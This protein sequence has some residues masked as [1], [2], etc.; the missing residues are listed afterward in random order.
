ML[1][2]SLAVAGWTYDFGRRMAGFQQSEAGET[3]KHL[4]EANA[5]L[6]EEVGRLRSLLA[7]S[8]NSLHIESAAQKQLAERNSFLAEENTRLKE[9]LAVF[10]RLTRLEGQATED[11]SLDRL[12]VTKAEGPGMYRFGFLIALQGKRRG[13]ESKFDLQIVVSPKTGTEGVKMTFPRSGEADAAQYELVLRN[14]RRIEGKFV[15]PTGFTV[16]AVEFRILESGL[17]KGSKSLAL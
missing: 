12:T 9:D 11:I 17:V 15:V 6:E 1:G 4:R 16:G 10:E 7:A 14:F 8:E 2:L 3:A 13:R 5:A